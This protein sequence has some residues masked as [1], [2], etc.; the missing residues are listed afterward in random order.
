MSEK[1]SWRFSPGH[2]PQMASG[3]GGWL[4]LLGINNSLS[5]RLFPKTKNEPGWAYYQIMSIKKLLLL[6]SYGEFCYT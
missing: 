4:A 1:S 2:A 5:I 6:S 3:L